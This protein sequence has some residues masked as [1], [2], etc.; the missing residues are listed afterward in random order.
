[1]MFLCEKVSRQGIDSIRILKCRSLDS[2]AVVPETIRGLP[3]TELAAYAFSS[4]RTFGM[5]E[6]REAFWWDSGTEIAEGEPI[7]GIKENP[8]LK[9]KLMTDISPEDSPF[10]EGSR[11]EELRLPR[12]LQRV[13][14]YA[15]YNCERLRKLEIYSTTLDWGAGVFNGC[16]GVRQLTLHVNEEQ[17]SC[18]KEILAELRQTLE[19]LYF[20]DSVTDST[21]NPAV[22]LAV[23]PAAVLTAGSG[24]LQPDTCLIFPE[25]F[26][27]AVENTPARIL[28]TQTHGCGQRYRNAFVQTQFQFKEYDS[29]FAHV[30]VQ[31]PEELVARLALGRLMHPCRLEETY[32]KKYMDYLAGHKV[33]AAGQAVRQ[34]NLKQLQ[35][36]FANIP[37]D[38]DQMDRLLDAANRA[39]SGAVISY[40]ME[41]KRRSGAVKRR[42][43]SI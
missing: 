31:E 17:R 42:K 1:M 21:T 13:G 28:V 29:L 36:L 40:L 38:G 9:E 23:D 37:Y 24:P 16:F 41:Q 7:A 27:E 2:L 43:F 25:Y 19:V 10:L 34:E 14:A 20:R 22:N 26:E 33:A 39:G 8:A 15:F 30:Q 35:W 5:S 18:M 32:R 12:S 4:H 3:V 11:L 6:N